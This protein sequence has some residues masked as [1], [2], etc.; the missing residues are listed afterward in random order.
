MLDLDFIEIPLYTALVMLGAL[1]GLGATWLYLRLRL[2]RAATLR[3]FLDGAIIVFVAGWIGARAYHVATHWDYYAARPDDIAQIGIGG[4]AMRGALILGFIALIFYARWRRF[5]PAKLLDATAIGLAIGQAI[6]WAG[7]LV[8][9][10]NYGIVSDSQIAMDLP[11]LYGLVAPRFPL[12]HAEIILFAVLGLGLVLRAFY[13]PQ[14]GML[15]VV[16][17]LIAS[18]ANFALAFQRGDETLGWS[19]LRIDQW[20]DL[21]GLGVV[22]LFW[23]YARRGGNVGIN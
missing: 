20:V 14:P 7:A 4:M 11:D 8:H 15:F 5:A 21:I 22:L 19:G 13:K 2:H 1:V 16:Y 9:G 23:R 10:A 12:Q 6:G 18:A 17:V 3:V